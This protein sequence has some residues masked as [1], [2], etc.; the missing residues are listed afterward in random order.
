MSLSRC[1]LSSCVFIAVPQWLRSFSCRECA[2]QM[3]LC[4]GSQ[5][6]SEGWMVFFPLGGI[7]YYTGERTTYH[8][9]TR[10]HVRLS[11]SWVDQWHL[12]HL[13]FSVH[14]RHSSHL[15]YINHAP[16]TLSLLG[17]CMWSWFLLSCPWSQLQVCLLVFYSCFA[18]LLVFLSAPCF[19][20]LGLIC[21]FIKVWPAAPGT[22]IFWLPCTVR[23]S[24]EF[25]AIS[26]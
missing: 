12:P 24:K 5:S 7:D 6:C 19:L 20:V 9:W 22:C 17:R 26:L 15:V 4:G 14:Q 13:W 21:W 3:V 25:K 8:I 23:S 18:L 1:F 16:L 10:L 2:S 11:L